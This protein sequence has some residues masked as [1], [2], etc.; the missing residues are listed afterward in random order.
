MELVRRRLS[1]QTHGECVGGWAAYLVARNRLVLGTLFVVVCRGYPAANWRH[2][3][4]GPGSH[5]PRSFLS[6]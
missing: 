6:G 5:P 2:E 4:K 3:R 1:S